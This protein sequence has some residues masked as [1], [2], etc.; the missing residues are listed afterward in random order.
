MDKLKS[1]GYITEADLKNEAENVYSGAVVGDGSIYKE[2]SVLKDACLRFARDRY[3]LLKMLS[4]KDI[5]TVVGS[6]CPNLMRKAVNS[7]KR[8]RAFARLDEGDVCG[9]CN[10]RGSCDRAYVMLKESEADA[11]TVDVVRILLLYALDP[12]VISEEKTSGRELIDASARQLL[13]ELIE[14]SETS[15]KPEHPIPV[16]KAPL[17]RSNGFKKSTVGEGWSDNAEMKRGDWICPKCNFLNFSRNT[18][19]RQCREDGPKSVGAEQTEMRKGDWI[20][21][22]CDFLNFS[23]NTNCRQCRE[24]KPRS[25]GA[26]QTEMKKGD[27]VCS[28]CEFINFSRNVRCLKCKTDGP[29]RV[30]MDDAEMKK[31]DWVCPDCGFMNFSTNRK[32]L[33]C[34]TPRPKRQ[35]NP[36]EWECPSCDFLNFKRNTV[37]LKCNNE[38]SNRLA[39]EKDDDH[40]WRSPR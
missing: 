26:E 7:A 9:D 34:P 31:G 17:Q 12:L 15:A 1:R 21:P 30:P 39:A 10:L 14:L 13:S 35:L 25:V 22:K 24:D 27:W 6:G 2:M 29:K 5:E 16:A 33:R 32:C 19:C 11:R 40:V 3:D 37:C 23:K 8:L 4:M 18:N 28:K 38:R 20:C 36:G